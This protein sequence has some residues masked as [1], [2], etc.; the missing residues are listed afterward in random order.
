MEAKI[1]QNSSAMIV[2]GSS[3]PP[4]P[5][6]SDGAVHADTS[7]REE[8]QASILRALS[9]LVR[10]DQVEVHS[11][12]HSPLARASGDGF[13][14]PEDNRFRGQDVNLPDFIALASESTPPALRERSASAGPSSDSRQQEEVEMTLP[15]PLAALIVG[16][17]ERRDQAASLGHLVAAI[18]R[19][20]SPEDRQ[21]LTTRLFEY[22]LDSER[23]AHR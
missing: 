1:D 20:A 12:S 2:G 10:N 22:M 3:T 15:G 7:N 16:P 4:S 5:D 17:R 14:Q 18:L 6:Q 21:A 8:R 23:S 9:T 11:R 13:S 19:D